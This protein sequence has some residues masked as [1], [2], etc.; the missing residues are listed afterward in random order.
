MT[1]TIMNNGSISDVTF[2]FSIWNNQE[3]RALENEKKAVRT[4]SVIRYFLHPLL[5][6]SCISKCLHVLNL[7][8]LQKFLYIS[9]EPHDILGICFSILKGDLLR[10]RNDLLFMNPSSIGLVYKTI[11]HGT[12]GVSVV[13]EEEDKVCMT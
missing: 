4:S 11:Y 13:F 7:L 9:E 8:F 3:R 10:E 6:E 1:D 2:H 5:S 12:I